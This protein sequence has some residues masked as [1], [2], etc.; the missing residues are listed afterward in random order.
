[1]EGPRGAGPISLLP[2]AAPDAP[3][4]PD[5]CDRPAGSRGKCSNTRAGDV[6][7][8]ANPT[9]LGGPDA[10]TEGEDVPRAT[11]PFRIHGRYWTRS[12]GS[13]GDRGTSTQDYPARLARDNAYVASWSCRGHFFAGSTRPEEAD[14]RKR[15]R[16]PCR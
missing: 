7:A 16:P 1:M 9:R 13:D 11:V 12:G 15:Y 5:G 4:V 6:L 2:P 10:F 8:S 14:M 3:F